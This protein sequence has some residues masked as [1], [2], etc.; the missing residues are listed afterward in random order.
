MQDDSRQ[1][2]LEM[3]VRLIAPGS[4]PEYFEE[5]ATTRNVSRDGFYFVTQSEHYEEGM[6]LSV[7]LPYHSPRDP[8]DRNYLAQVVRVELLDN[9]QRGVAIQL[10]SSVKAETI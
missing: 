6:R 5:I 1:Y 3:C 8:I 7:T 4:Y 9:A 2:H 10:L